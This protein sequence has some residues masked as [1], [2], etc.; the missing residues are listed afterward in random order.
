MSTPPDSCDGTP[1]SGRQNRTAVSLEC[2]V[3]QGSRPWKQ[4]RLEDLSPQGFRISRFPECNPHLP[5]RIRIPGLE[6]LTAKVRWQK[7]DAVG[8]EFASPLHVAVFE[9]IVRRAMLR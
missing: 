3:R 5:L 4:T 6:L 2:E 7:A 1:D 8:C 9:H